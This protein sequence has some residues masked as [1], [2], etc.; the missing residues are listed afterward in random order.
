MKLFDNKVALVTGASSGIGHATARLL[1]EQG[2]RVLVAARRE[3]EL[4]ALVEDIRIAGG[5]AY[6]ASKHGQIGLT[7]SASAE[8][9]PLGI[10]VNLVCPGAIN[11]P[12]HQRL[13]GVSGDAFFDDVFLPTVHLR[14]AGRSEEIAQSILFL[15]SDAAS[16]ITGTTVTPDGGYSLTM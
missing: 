13:R 2:A 16:Y 12:M 1:A 8:F 9:A 5:S 14:R 3:A 15:C 6:V 7:T 10:R 4:A 11:T